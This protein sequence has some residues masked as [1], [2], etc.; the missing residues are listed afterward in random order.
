[1]WCSRSI[2]RADD[3]HVRSEGRHVITT[4]YTEMT[5]RH[6][7]ADWTPECGDLHPL[8]SPPVLVEGGSTTELPEPATRRLDICG[9]RFNIYRDRNKWLGLLPSGKSYNILDARNSLWQY[10]DRVR[11]EG[12]RVARNDRPKFLITLIFSAR[13][14]L[15]IFLSQTTKGSILILVNKCFETELTLFRI[16]ILE[17]REVEWTQLYRYLQ[18][19]FAIFS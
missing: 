2:A 13:A 3:G 1:M 9:M 10:F 15:G 19:S 6:S 12:F 5:M 18:W 4:K 14:W 7:A 16:V 11:P 8:P 17:N